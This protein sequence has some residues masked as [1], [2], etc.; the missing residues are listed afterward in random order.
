[1]AHDSYITCGMPDMYTLSPWACSSQAL[2]V[3][4]RQTTCVHGR[5]ITYNIIYLYH[6]AWEVQRVW[7][8]YNHPAGSYT[9]CSGNL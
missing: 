3:H 7:L 9:T 4:V 6:S 8:G 2:G 5:T 1:M